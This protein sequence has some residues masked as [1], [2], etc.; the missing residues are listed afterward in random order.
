MQAL[1]A[2]AA[3]G[4]H[5][6]LKSWGPL[7]QAIGIFGCGV[8]LPPACGASW[9]SESTKGGEEAA[10]AAAAAAA[11]GEYAG[12]AELWVALEAVWEFIFLQARTFVRF[13]NLFM[14]FLPPNQ[15]ASRACCLNVRPPGLAAWPAVRIQGRNM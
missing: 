4:P 11:G 12:D 7:F 13:I 2:L 3:A 15:R 1:G 9:P 5:L 10:A 8:L 14:F 6:C